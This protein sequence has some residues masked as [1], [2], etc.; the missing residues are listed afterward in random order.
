MFCEIGQS[1][2]QMEHCFKKSLE[3]QLGSIGF[4]FT[5]GDQDHPNKFHNMNG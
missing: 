4:I 5:M 2:I 1:S 3:K